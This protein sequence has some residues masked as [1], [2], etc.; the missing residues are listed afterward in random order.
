MLSTQEISRETQETRSLQQGAHS[1]V[2]TAERWASII[3]G[4]ALT[5]YGLKRG[6]LDGTL[7]A[8]L[9]GAL[10]YRGVTGHSYLY[11]ALSIDTT[12]RSKRPLVSV[13]YNQGIRV[14]KAVTIN[15]SPEE[16]YRFWHNFENLPCFMHHLKAVTKLSDKQS[17][18]VAKG[19]AGTSVEWD[20]DIINDQENE[21]IAWRS[22]PNAD[23]DHAGSVH[24]RRAPGGRGT[25]VKVE[26]EYRPPAGSVSAAVASIFGEEPSQQMEEDLHRL[27]QW[28]EAGEIATTYGQPGG[29]R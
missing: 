13:P 16:L 6:E 3:G 17:H 18:W 19:P 26:M 5:L 29:L 10:L 14:E 27:K 21:W 1:N 9:G 28:M 11:G 23:V 25:E 8:L 20:A 7:L 4:G 2:G 22:L 12:G 15:R 24:F